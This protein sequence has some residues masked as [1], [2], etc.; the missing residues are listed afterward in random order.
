MKAK[1]VW[2]NVGNLTLAKFMLGHFI[3]L[4]NEME[5]KGYWI[6]TDGFSTRDGMCNTLEEGKAACQKV[7]S[8]LISRWSGKEKIW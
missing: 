5:N 3:V 4:Y 6:F 1:L 2:K 7:A 8:E